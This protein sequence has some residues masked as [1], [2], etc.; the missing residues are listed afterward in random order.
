VF[1][2][3]DASFAGTFLGSTENGWV[4]KQVYGN[5]NSNQTIK[6]ITG[7]HSL[8]SGFHKAMAAALSS[9]SKSLSKNMFYTRFM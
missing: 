6:I 3:V 9:K 1:S 2:I 7:V 5:Q 8:E 4:E